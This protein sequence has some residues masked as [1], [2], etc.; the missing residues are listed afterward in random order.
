VAILLADFFNLPV[1]VLHADYQTNRKTRK[2]P[3]SSQ[4]SNYNFLLI[5]ENQL[6][7]TASLLFQKTFIQ[8][9]LKKYFHLPD[10][11]Y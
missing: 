8:I 5:S 6:Q 1:A 10:P 9:S 4:D 7:K 2:K 11:F 3:N